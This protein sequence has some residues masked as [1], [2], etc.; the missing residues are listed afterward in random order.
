METIELIIPDGV[1]FSDLH[2]SR[3]VVT[4]EIEFDTRQ[5][6]I[7]VLHNPSIRRVFDTEDGTASF[8]VAWYRAHRAAGGQ[9]DLVQE[10]ILAEIEAEDRFGE[11]RVQIGSGS[12]N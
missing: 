6:D 4:G 10:Q 7:V 2:L 11:W 8:L 12:M 5:I 9:A 1:N 3:D